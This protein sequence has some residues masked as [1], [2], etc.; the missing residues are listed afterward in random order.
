MSST[1]ESG[2]SETPTRIEVISYDKS[3]L[4]ESTIAE[5]EQLLEFLGKGKTVWFNVDGGCADSVLQQ[6]AVILQLHE[7]AL[8]DVMNPRQRAKVDDYESH[9]YIVMRMADVRNFPETEQLNIFLGRDFVLTIQEKPGGDSLD[10]V[11][12]RI[13]KN[14]GNL[15]KLG[16]DYLMYSIVDQ[17][18]D[19]YF[20]V[21]EALGERIEQLEDDVLE[22]QR[23]KTPARIHEV[24]REVQSIRRA[25]WPLRD[26]VSALCRDEHALIKPETRLYLRDCY[27]HAVRIIDLIETYRELSHDLMDI[28][29]S[30]ANNKMNEV[31]KVLTIITSLF[32]PPSFIAGVYGMNFDRSKSPFN[33]PE[34]GWYYG[35]PFCLLLMLA[36]AATLMFYLHKKGWLFPDN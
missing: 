33:M 5:P 26:A 1:P 13:R 25:I 7:L 15:R 4:S 35:Y 14:R 36:L 16:A 28:Y 32:I 30:T 9:I 10:S 8:E 11:R 3:D 31:M 23:Q 21:I 19:G 24:K 20:P 34:L 12:D 2:S 22:D 27:D 6:L 18:V 29:L 17:I